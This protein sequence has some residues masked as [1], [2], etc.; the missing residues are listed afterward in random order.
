MSNR[1]GA[2]VEPAGQAGLGWAGATRWQRTAM[3]LS[4]SLCALR[5]RP[6]TTSGRYKRMEHFHTSQTTLT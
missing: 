6:F 1:L 5:I 4:T 3:C 2:V